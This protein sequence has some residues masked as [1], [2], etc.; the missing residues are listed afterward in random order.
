MKHFFNVSSAYLKVL[1]LLIVVFIP[2]I[3]F[4]QYAPTSQYAPES[5]S[6][7]KQSQI[8]GDVYIGD[9]VWND[10]NGNGIQE[11]GESGIPNVLVVLYD[12]YGNQISTKYTDSNGNYS[13]YCSYNCLGVYYIKFVAP[14]GYVFSPMDQGN[15]SAIDSDADPSTGNTRLL[16]ID[17]PGYCYKYDAGMYKPATIGDYVWND[18]DQDGYQ[19]YSE[20]GISNVT[21]Y[22]Y[23]SNN[24]Y[25]GQTTTNAAGYYEFTNIVPGSYY[26][27]FILKSGYTFSPQ[28]QG[29]NNT[30]DSDANTS[31]GKTTVTTL[32]AGEIDPTWDAG[33]YV[34]TQPAS[35]GDRVWL[36]TDED[37][38]QDVGEVGLP[39]VTVKLYTSG[40]GLVGTT[41]TNSSGIYS[42][43]NLSLGSYYVEFT[44]PSGYVLSPQNQGSN[45]TVDS[46]A[47]ASTGQTE[48][49][50]LT[51]G[52]NDTSWDAGMYVQTQPAS[53]GDRVWL[54]TDEDGIQDVGEVGLPNVTVKL[55]TSGGGLVGTT[56]TNS[57]GIY[58]FTNLSLGSYYVEFTTP[59][60]YVLSPQ[61]QGSNDTVDS[62]ASAST[63]QTETTTLTSG[64]N[65]TSWD[66]GM[67]VQTQPASIGD[68][69]WLDTDEDG[70]QDVGEVGLPNV[71]VKLYTS[72]GGLVGTTTTNSSGIYSFTNLSLGSY[73]VEF[74]TPSGYVLSPQNQG[75]NDTVDSDASASTGQTETTTLTSG[76]NDTSW[77]AGMYQPEL[78]SIGDYFWND[79]NEDGI[80][81]ANENGVVSNSVRLFKGDGSFVAATMT[82]ANGYY[83]FTDLIPGDYYVHFGLGSGYAFS[84]KDQGGDDTKDS[85]VDPSTGNTPVT[86]LS[87]GE[88]D[89]SWDA[90]RYVEVIIPPPSTPTCNI[91]TSFL[92][93]NNLIFDGDEIYYDVRFQQE[94]TT[95]YLIPG[96]YP[97]E[98]NGA[99][100]I[101]IAEAIAWDGDVY[102]PSVG[103]EPNER[104]KV[105]FVKDGSVVWS[106]PYTGITGGADGIDTGVVSDEWVGPLG[107][108]TTLPNGADEIWLVH[109]SDNTY[110]EGDNSN[111]NDVYPTSVCIEYETS[112]LASIG[113]FVWYDGNQ[114]GQQ[115]SNGSSVGVPN[116]T[117]ELFHS[118]GASAGSTTTDANG[119][120]SFTGLTPGD[121][122]LKFSNI[123]G[124]YVLTDKDQGG[125]NSLD[126]DADPSTG[127]TAV[128]TLTAGENDTSWDAG[129]YEETQPQLGSIG[130][131]VWHDTFHSST[132]QVDG[133]QDVGELGIEGVLVQLLVDGSV[134]DTYTT[135]SDGFYEFTDLSAG[136]YT[137]R[138]ATSNFAVGGVLEDWYAAPQ[139]QGSDDTVDS[140]GSGT[141]TQP[142]QQ[143]VSLSAGEHNPTIDFGFFFSCGKLTKTGP[144]SVQ[145]GETITYH[146]VY[147]NC[148]DIVHSG[149]AKVY[150]D[151]INPVS[152]HLIWSYSP[153]WPGEV[154]EFDRTY[155]TTEDDCGELENCAWSVGHTPKPYGYTPDLPDDFDQDCWT[156]IVV[157]EDLDYGDLPSPY[158]TLLAND[159][160]RHIIDDVTYLGASVDAETDGLP[161]LDALGDDNDVTD[162][163]NGVDFLTLV[164]GGDL[165][166]EVVVSTNGYLN[167]WVDFNYDGD[168]NDTL[169]NIATDL[170]LT[171][172]THTLTFPAPADA[173]D[174]LYSRFRFTSGANQ[175]TSV[176]GIA[177]NGEVEDY[178]EEDIPLA[179]TLSSFTANSVNGQVEL[180]W[181]TESEIENQGFVL[182]R[183]M[184]NSGDDWQ[185]LASYTTYPELR[186]Q[187]TVTYSTTYEFTDQ[188]VQLGQ[189]YEYR[190]A[191]IDYNGTITYHS[192]RIVTV[193]DGWGTVTPSEFT[194]K[195]AYPNP[196][197]PS[198]NI[199]YAIPNDG[200]VNIAIYDLA[201]QRV[202]SL[203][204]AEQKAGWHKVRWNGNDNT[205]NSMPAGVYLVT[206]KAGNSLKT[207]KLIFVK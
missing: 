19:D 108:L 103:D 70:I 193:E 148:G 28:D 75:S 166:I 124:G 14:V 91:S 194:V 101:T 110:G 142:F 41:T 7:S 12:E 31:T 26:V 149:G 122:Y 93:E 27:K 37:G 167:A 135:T 72:G 206:I 169:E 8:T 141:E 86:T 164:P 155:V 118:G 188:F 203:V 178:Y 96:P 174:D 170:Y 90:G 1:A 199:E 33:M 179:V 85:D 47:S 59:S 5:Q 144:T 73:Y 38:I 146:F 145:A 157:C 125:D 13:F 115:N 45:D 132:H 109:W 192:S 51:S 161:S 102:R 113:D 32:I 71:T 94:S 114:D 42:F 23:K 80:Q 126:S 100:N 134:V 117:V 131:Y 92:W 112:Q 64:E 21:V 189:T 140:D 162:D 43:T 83:S 177:S 172:G 138:I 79:T 182:E 136:D 44:T 171:T 190:L 123:P 35:I 111:N 81:D 205:G 34:Q 58:S 56:T 152:L 176:T 69:V 62:D 84:P 89:I 201:G 9:F 74:T 3:I 160:A 15:D 60:G 143:V 11:Y 22:L 120:Y 207:M 198:T 165:E 10:T 186:G 119:F 49:T 39:N 185:G 147:E 61:N 16:N 57:S 127:Q 130:N 95:K 87:P 104:F 197:N 191:D 156:V 151:M 18:T 24:T 76:E 168:F 204:E 159:G 29:S 66:A 54:D 98:F 55:Y 202:S 48:T 63:G 82:D 116:V 181:V 195:P 50:T 36:D 77:D 67:Y 133:I 150:D 30:K 200:F 20:S 68:R 40:G 129:I 17:S 2:N 52:E 163:E 88:N 173:S 175:A 180:I 184:E 139:N 97:S 196:F 4:S 137:V 121:Y 99:V 46:D 187:G 106:S 105:V 183:R 158:P 65:D 53:I 107:G 6:L 78:A 128:T 154:K 153:V 25:V